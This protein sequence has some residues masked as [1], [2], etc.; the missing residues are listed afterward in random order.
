LLG[1]TKKKL[2]KHIGSESIM[3]T[4]AGLSHPELINNYERECAFT[5]TELLVVMATLAILAAVMLPALAK[6]GDNGMRTVCLNNLRQLGTA[7]NMYASE[8][9]DIMPWVN[10][11]QD[12]S[13]PC[14]PGWLYAG[15]PN[16]PVNLNTGNL[17]SDTANWSTNR[18]ANLKTGVY[19]QYIQNPDAFMCPVDAAMDVGTALWEQRNNKLSS[20]VMNGASAY[21]PANNMNNLVG[22][23]TCK[24]SQV[25]SPS[26]I[27]QWE[28]AENSGAGNG[29]NDGANYPTSSEGPS[30]A[31]HGT[32]GNVLT[33]GGSARVMSFAGLLAEMNHPLKGV[34]TQGKGL[35]WWNPI[36]RDG[37]GQLY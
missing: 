5:L 4:N 13:P 29:Y 12:P 23:K 6:S 20:Y 10:W 25:W 15:N 26:C 14:P 7:L 35:F 31:L 37:H 34:A 24:T 32:G 16:T 18:V 2:P 28:P 27:I 21:F 22:Y 11:G 3:K 9:Q 19:W 8:N 1:N 17:A 33:V 30:I 36:T